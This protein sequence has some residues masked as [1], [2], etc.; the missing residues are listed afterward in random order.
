M[1]HSAEVNTHDQ[2]LFQGIMKHPH[3]SVAVAKGGRFY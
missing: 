1:F 3:L 2:R